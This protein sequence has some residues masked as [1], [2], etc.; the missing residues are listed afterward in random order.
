MHRALF[1]SS[2]VSQSDPQLV[3][4]KFSIGTDL[5]NAL[6]HCIVLHLEFYMMRTL[7]LIHFNTFPFIVKP[8]IIE[9]PVY[10]LICI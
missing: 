7:S 5:T 3:P 4:E 2:A 10:D 1:Q 8:V 6:Y 9:I